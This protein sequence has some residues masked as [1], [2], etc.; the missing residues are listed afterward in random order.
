MLRTK[1]N[2]TTGHLRTGGP[3]EEN[4]EK[5]DIILILYTYSIV[6]VLA[7]IEIEK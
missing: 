6:I 7:Q 3:R 4:C 1:T 5:Y 2:K